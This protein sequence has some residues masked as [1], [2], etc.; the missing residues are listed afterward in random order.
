M[1]E[2]GDQEII[3]GLG[4]NGFAVRDPLSVE[5]ALCRLQTGYVYHYAFAMIIGIVLMIS[6]YYWSLGK[7]TNGHS[8]LSQHD[9]FSPAF[10]SSC[11]WIKSY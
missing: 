8:S 3:D 7:D 1:W 6:Y 9:P 5:G 4:P 11:T 2:E 10:G